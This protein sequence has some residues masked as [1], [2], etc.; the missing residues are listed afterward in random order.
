[1]A[2]NVLQKPVRIDLIGYAGVEA[3]Q[4]P[5][6]IDNV[7]AWQFNRVYMHVA[8]K[9]LAAGPDFDLHLLAR[10]V[11]SG[12]VE[13]PARAIRG[14]HIL[15]APLHSSRLAGDGQRFWTTGWEHGNS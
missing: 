13:V 3:G 10:S 4:T 5:P 1:M 6:V 7:N 9:P 2:R 15:P 12:S 14:A 8:G 11:V